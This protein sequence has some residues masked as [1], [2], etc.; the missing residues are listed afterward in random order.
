MSMFG[1]VKPGIETSFT[2]TFTEAD[3]GFFCAISGDFD[4]LHVNEHY[5][6]TTPFGKRIAHGLA[7]LGLLSAPE[8]ALSAR[9]IDGGS[10]RRPVTLGYDRLRFLAPVFLGD[11]LTA[12]Y[13]IVE[14]D[15]T[16]SRSTAEC[17][18][19]RHDGEL[20]VVGRHIMKWV[21]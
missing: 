9:A 1:D 7:V 17:T 13:R 8:A 4:P 3:L 11:T 21:G 16:T 10:P 19:T 15:E 6:A 18:I 20:C 14:L 12:R 5:A 2:K